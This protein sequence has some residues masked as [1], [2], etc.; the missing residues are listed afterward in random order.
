MT[1]TE[2]LRE[3]IK[4]IDQEIIELI[5]TRLEIADE[6]AEAKKAS[7]QDK[8]DSSV[9][10][11]II[12]RYKMLCEEVALSEEEAEHIAKVILKISRE[13]QNRHFK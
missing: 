12:A 11:E 9:E 13:R 4:N 2:E 8:W 1:N 10:R 7:H 3:M 6:L 5:A